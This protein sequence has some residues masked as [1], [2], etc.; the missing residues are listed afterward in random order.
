MAT[1]FD[2]FLAAADAAV[3]GIYSEPAGLLP[4]AAGEFSA[5]LSDPARPSLT[6]VGVYSAGAGDTLI[7]G[8]AQGEFLGTT[9]MATTRHEFW[10]APAQAAAV[11]YRIAPGDL[12]Q[13]RGVAFEI[14][15]V[16]PSDAGDINLILAPEG[17]AT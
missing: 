15:Y 7:K 6:I 13:V 2:D 16:Q 17:A 10:I 11:P 12:V 8:K 14:V 9:R 1:A 4:R 3:E 5:R